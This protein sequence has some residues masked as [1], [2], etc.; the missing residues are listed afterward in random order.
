LDVQ[1]FEIDSGVKIRRHANGPT[2]GGGNSN[3]IEEPAPPRFDQTVA[4]NGG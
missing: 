2:T 1:K 4:T 3:T